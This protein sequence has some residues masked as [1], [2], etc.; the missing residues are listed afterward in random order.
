M[1][2]INVRY[3]LGF[4]LFIILMIG[5]WSYIYD[6]VFDVGFTDCL[7]SIVVAFIIAYRFNKKDSKE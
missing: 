3:F 1:L 2:F 6:G 4:L 5:G 7:M